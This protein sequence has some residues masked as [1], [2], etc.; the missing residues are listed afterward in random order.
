MEMPLLLGCNG[1]GAM[2]TAE[3]AIEDQFRLVKDSAVFDYFDRLPQP[4]QV[5]EYIRCAQKFNLPIHTVTWYY[6]LG[7]DEHLIDQ[8]LRIG[9]TVGAKTHNIMIFTRHAD[10]HPLSDE[11]ITESY[12]S[13]W[14]KAALLGL[15]PSFELHVNMWSEDFRRVGRIANKVRERGIPFNF[16]LDYSHVIFK[17]ENPEEQDVCGIREDVEAGVLVLDP[18]EAGNLCDVWLDMGIVLWAQMRPVA[19][20]GPKNIWVQDDAG[21]PG[22]G[23]QYPFMKPGPGEWHSPWYAY[24]IEPSKEAMRKILRYHVTHRTS[25]LRYITTE[26]INLPDY[27]MNAKYS[28]IEHNIACARWI[29]RTWNEL[30]IEEAAANQPA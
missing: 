12:L 15:E 14:D 16:T 8:N 18:F 27:G 21:K 26:M 20:N 24:K 2:H 7:R 29:R 9:A 22:R 6:M 23:I 4:D 11:E 25:P 3:P 10:G 30:V 13:S 5:D 17:I 28:L 19:P 1:R